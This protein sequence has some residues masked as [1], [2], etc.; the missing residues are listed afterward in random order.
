MLLKTSATPIWGSFRPLAQVNKA[1]AA[2]III[3]SS[4]LL[5]ACSG[6]TKRPEPAE[7]GANTPLLS[8]R[9]A[10]LIRVGELP[11]GSQP[12]V[13]GSTVVVAAAD[14]NGP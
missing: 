11:A 7:L 1:R 3:A 12:A 13:V 2:I 6:N 5:S 9:Q 14:G 10:W 4:V 8:V